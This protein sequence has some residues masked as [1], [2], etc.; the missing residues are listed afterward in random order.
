MR[1]APTAAALAP[2]YIAAMDTTRTPLEAL[3]AQRLS[4]EGLNCYVAGVGAP[5]LLL[6]SVNATASAAEV[7]PLFEH[8]RATRTVFALD[9][10]GFGLSDMADQRYSLRQMTDAVHATV[11][12]LGTLHV[13]FVASPRFVTMSKQFIRNNSQISRMTRHVLKERYAQLAAAYQTQTSRL[14]ENLECKDRAV[15]TT[16]GSIVHRHGS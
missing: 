7:R 10:P 4:F 2:A 8:Y 5:L 1:A 6:H 16:N 13:D 9:L 12:E 3:Q 15:K 14:N 11:D